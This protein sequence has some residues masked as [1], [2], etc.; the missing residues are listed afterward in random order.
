[1]GGGPGGGQQLD[2]KKIKLIIKETLAGQ[3]I[4]KL[5]RLNPLYKMSQVKINISLKIPVMTKGLSFSCRSLRH[6]KK[7]KKKHFPHRKV[8]PFQKY[9]RC[10]VFCCWFF[11][12][13][14]I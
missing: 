8:K 1:V 11:L 3:A 9:N 2:C 14:L 5:Y 6:Q 10:R 4:G 13:F 12:C 7:K